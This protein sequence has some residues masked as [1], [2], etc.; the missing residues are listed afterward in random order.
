[1][2]DKILKRYELRRNS[3]KYTSLHVGFLILVVLNLG[4]TNKQ[5][6]REVIGCYAPGH[7]G[8]PY[9]DA[10][11]LK[12]TMRKDTS[13][14]NMVWIPAGKFEMGGSNG[15]GY[16]E[17]YPLHSVQVKGFWMDV[18]EVTNAEFAA[19]VQ[20]TKY[21]TM[22]EQKPD[23]EQMKLQ[24]PKDTP[25][26]PDSLL[27][28][29]SLVFTP[30]THAVELTNASVWWQFVPG[31]NWQH[32]EGSQSSI[33]GKENHPVVHVCWA[34]AMSYCKWAGK[35]LPTEA[36]WEWAAK[37]GVQNAIYGWGNVELQDGFYPA[38]IWQGQFPN[39]NYL[40]DKFY[41]TAPVQSFAANAY[42]LYDMSGNVWEWCG[43]WMDASY[44]ATVANQL[45]IDPVGPAN[46][47]A[48]SH[49]Y[50][51]VL[52][53]GS[54]LCHESYC[55]GYR[56]ARRSSNGWETGSNHAGFRCVK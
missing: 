30:P 19:F 6:D 46:E 20:A 29:G 49:P 25:K 41:A 34:D 12:I 37:G 21:V 42:G 45:S 22:A 14:E 17:E 2:F 18:H 8:L 36:E 35:R 16:A 31:A 50:Q 9:V 40:L 38:N 15:E 33:V 3:R 24:L 13:C 23:W 39:D 5:A 1:M 47:S 53:G 11:L 56:T 7:S 27:V 48:T 55:T 4:C 26:P 51:K 32:P 52:K 43:D 28:A 54:F 10:H 44:Y